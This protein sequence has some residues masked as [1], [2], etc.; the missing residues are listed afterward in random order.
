MRFPRFATIWRN[1][2][3]ALSII[4]LVSAAAQQ[5]EKMTAE[6]I[7]SA[8]GKAVD[9]VPKFTWLSDNSAVLFDLRVPK[10]ERNFERLDPKSGKRTPMIDR[11][12][13][14]K[15]DG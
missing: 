7:Y 4:L 12:A 15:N 9:D 11:A 6:W 5:P 2:L 14:G 13:A 10:A 1:L 8:A 3:A